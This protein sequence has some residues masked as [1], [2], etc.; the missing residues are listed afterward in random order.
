[1]GR[2]PKKSCNACCSVSETPTPDPPG[3]PDPNP[4]PNYRSPTSCDD[5]I[6]IVLLGSTMVSSSQWGGGWSQ[7]RSQ[8]EIAN[9]YPLYLRTYQKQHL[10][11]YIQRT[12]TT[13]LLTSHTLEDSDITQI[14]TSLAKLGG[15]LES[16]K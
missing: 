15:G 7:S 5:M 3:T 12:I 9:E 8:E 1:M 6:N 4:D 2:P 11:F 16:I 14:K 13:I 10:A